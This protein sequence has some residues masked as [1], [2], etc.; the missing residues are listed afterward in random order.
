M[1]TRR[2]SL[3]NG[4]T[5][6]DAILMY[7]PG[8]VVKPVTVMDQFFTGVVRDVD[9]K[10]N[11]VTV[12]WGG[13]PVSQHDPDEIMPMPFFGASHHDGTGKIASRRMRADVDDLLSDVPGIDEETQQNP[14]DSIE[15]TDFLADDMES[16]LNRQVGSEFYSAYLY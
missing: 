6:G 9:L 3:L 14:P 11:K 13:G 4:T 8:D 10:I 5:F 15:Q 1:K 7:K 12:A 16:L 2:G